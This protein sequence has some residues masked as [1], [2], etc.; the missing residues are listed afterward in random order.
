MTT[1]WWT[2]RCSELGFQSTSKP[3]SVILMLMA[4]FFCL[5]RYCLLFDKDLGR[6]RKKPL[7]QCSQGSRSDGAF[8]PQVVPD[9]REACAGASPESASEA[10]VIGTVR[11]AP[12]PVPNARIASEIS[13][14]RLRPGVLLFGIPYLPV[15]RCRLLDSIGTFRQSITESVGV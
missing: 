8:V 10:L 7:R 2:A 9:R 6:S 11:E 1:V 14:P 4:T 5:P 3:R 13:L 15:V 12:T